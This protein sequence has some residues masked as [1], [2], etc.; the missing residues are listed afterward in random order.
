MRGPNE[1]LR[2]K[3]AEQGFRGRKR[4]YNDEKKESSTK[5]KRNSQHHNGFNGKE[6]GGVNDRQKHADTFPLP[7]PPSLARPPLPPPP[8]EDHPH[9]HHLG[10][11]SNSRLFP[12]ISDEAYHHSST[13]HRGDLD[14]DEILLHRQQQEHQNRAMEMFRREAMAVAMADQQH[15]LFGHTKFPPPPPPAI[16]DLSMRHPHINI[17]QEDLMPPPPVR[18]RSY[19]SPPPPPPSVIAPPVTTRNHFNGHASQPMM[20]E[21]HHDET[22]N[23]DEKSDDGPTPSSPPQQH[24]FDEEAHKLT[25]I[26]CHSLEEE[27]EEEVETKPFISPTASPPDNPMRSRTTPPAP[28]IPGYGSFSSTFHENSGRITPSFH[29]RHTQRSPPSAESIICEPELPLGLSS[30]NSN[31]PYSPASSSSHPPQRPSEPSTPTGSE[32]AFPVSLLAMSRPRSMSRSY[33]GSSS[34]SSGDSSSGCASCSEDEGGANSANAKRR[35]HELDF[36]TAGAND[37]DLLEFTATRESD[38]VI[39]SRR[40]RRSHCHQMLDHHSS[41]VITFTQEEFKFI[42]FIRTCRNTIIGKINNAYYNEEHRD[43]LTSIL[44]SR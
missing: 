31:S 39:V 21:K 30:N 17:R 7:P 29:Y 33:A 22:I 26:L 15:S 4:T 25:Q 34:S 36:L 32:Q 40:R 24:L 14:E 5:S 1:S 18:D 35:K 28:Y 41:P 9:H 8:H 44:M 11:I 10:N 20:H 19:E 12:S 37:E 23:G 13:A 42:D 2:K 3:R 38:N 6:G 27:E 43:E 16:T